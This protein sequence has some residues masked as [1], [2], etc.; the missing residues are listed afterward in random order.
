MLPSFKISNGGESIRVLAKWADAM[1]TEYGALSKSR[2]VDYC[3]CQAY[4]ISKMDDNYLSQKW[5]ISH[6][7]SVGGRSWERYSETNKR[8]KYYEDK[9]LTEHDLS[10]TGLI[11]SVKDMS[12]HPLAHLINTDY[13]ETTKKRNLGTDVG[14]YICEK[15]T[16]LYTP[17][18]TSCSCCSLSEPCQERTKIMFPEL[19]RI[20]MEAWES[21]LS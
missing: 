2:I 13:E 3:V 1:E 10:R 19:Y 5:K 20:R 7:F 6:S 12:T 9:W 4:Q 8:V 16:L 18:S 14:Y 11:G 17:F 21:Q 15:S